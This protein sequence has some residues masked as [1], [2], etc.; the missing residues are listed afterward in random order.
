[1]VARCMWIW[2]MLTRLCPPDVL[3]GQLDRL[4]SFAQLPNVRL[5]IIGFATPY[6]VSPWHGFSIYDSE[7]VLVETFSA[8]LDLR[9]RQ[10]IGLYSDAFEQLAVVASYGRAARAIIT[11]VADELAPEVSDNGS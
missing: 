3:L 6:V 8:A 7:R 4:M 2:S 1:M 11:R 10:E 9:Q 5:G